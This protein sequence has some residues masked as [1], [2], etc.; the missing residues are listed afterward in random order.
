MNYKKVLD[1]RTFLKGVGGTIIGLPLLD[2][3]R[4]KSVYAAAPGSPNRAF[5]IFLVW[6]TNATRKKK[7]L[8]RPMAG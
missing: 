2:E 8:W 4:I 3:M 5:N 6:V 7:A 1:R